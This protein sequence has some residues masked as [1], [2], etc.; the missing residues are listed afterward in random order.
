MIYHV[1]LLKGLRQPYLNAQV[2]AKAEGITGFWKK[3]I[4]LALSTIILSAVTAYFGIGNEILSR[5]IDNLTSTEFEAAKIMFALGQI[6]WSLFAA[7]IVVTVP[8]L[9]FWTLSNSEWKKF[10]VVQLYVLS[11]FLLEKAITAIFTVTMGLAEISN[12]FSFGVIGQTFTQHPIM[13]HFLAEITLFKIWAMVL[14]YK[15]VKS[16]SDKSALMTLLI[17]LG[18]NF[19]LL[20]AV[21]F[22]NA[23]QLEKLL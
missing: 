16:L 20:L 18:L 13:L 22:F 5:N 17:V 7:L 15:Y 12:P 3:I 9:F 4:L 11:I 19:I 14:Q 23:M 1:R 8:S 2:L 6:L 21:V 10:I